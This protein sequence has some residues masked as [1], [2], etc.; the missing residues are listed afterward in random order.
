[1]GIKK[2]RVF[3]PSNKVEK[4]EVAKILQRKLEK[5]GKVVI[6]LGRAS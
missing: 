5:G 3:T 4:E 1:M 6:R 2:L